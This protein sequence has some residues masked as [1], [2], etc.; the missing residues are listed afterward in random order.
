MGIRIP[1][2]SPT[3]RSASTA[4]LST[5]SMDVIKSIRTGGYPSWITFSVCIKS[6]ADIL[7][8]P[9]PNLMRTWRTFS[10]FAD[11]RE[12]R[13]SISPVYRGYPWNATAYPP[14][15]ANSTSASINKRKNSLK[16]WFGLLP[17]FKILPPQEFQ[18]FKPAGRSLGKPVFLIAGVIMEPPFG[19]L[20]SDVSVEFRL[21]HGTSGLAPRFH[22]HTKGSQSRSIGECGPAASQA[23]LTANNPNRRGHMGPLSRP[24][25]LA[26]GV[27]PCRLLS[28]RGKR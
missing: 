23:G 26:A 19:D 28:G 13:I 9:N 1:R 4:S 16:S 18:R 10:A 2:K 17:D 6:S 21:V 22:Y 24:A 7:R 5:P 11:S 14:I 15:R 8:L 25:R 3:T 20:R 12:T 27:R